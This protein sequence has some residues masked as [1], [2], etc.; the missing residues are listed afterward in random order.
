MKKDVLYKQLEDDMMTLFP[1]ATKVLVVSSDNK[2]VLAFEVKLS[3]PMYDVSCVKFQGFKYNVEQVKGGEDKSWL[4][5]REDSKPEK[6]DSKI[7]YL[8]GSFLRQHTEE[9][10]HEYIKN[11]IPNYALS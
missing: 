10:I 4:F 9:E 1:L 2:G 6:R 8:S 3:R 7:L 11:Y 5:Y